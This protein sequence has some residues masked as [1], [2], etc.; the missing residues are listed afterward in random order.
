MTYAQ[1]EALS[2]VWG[3]VRDT[4]PI[5]VEDQEV[6]VTVNLHTALRNLRHD[7]RERIL[8]VDALCIN[9][10]D[11]AE[12]NSQIIM[13][14]DIYNRA[15]RVLAY[16]GDYFS[17]CEVA[18]EI[19]EKLGGDEDM[20]LY[21]HMSPGLKLTNNRTRGR[22]FEDH[23][24]PTALHRFLS[25]PWMTRVWTVQEFMMASQVV[26]LYGQ[27]EMRSEVLHAA[28]TR[29]SRHDAGCCNLQLH[30]PELTSQSSQLAIARHGL[31][32]LKLE[33]D[34]LYRQRTQLTSSMLTLEAFRHREATDQR[35]RVYG[36][37]G[38]FGAG[39]KSL[40][41]TDY[42]MKL[43]ELYKQAA[44]ADMHTTGR[45]HFLNFCYM[46]SRLKMASWIPDWSTEWTPKGPGQT[47]KWQARHA[48]HAR[49]SLNM[50]LYSADG[51]RPASAELT[52]WNSLMIRGIAIGGVAECSSTIIRGMV[53]R[54]ISQIRAMTRMDVA[55]AEGKFLCPSIP[56][57]ILI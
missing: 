11:V 29:F 3:S 49:M 32:S 15:I 53:P 48:L 56:S 23:D 10:Q 13:M 37:L 42:S 55:W 21:S 1:Y 34:M 50:S 4:K 14:A 16:L 44:L 41:R 52:L 46:G 39:W 51:G 22:G 33:W 30:P 25:S 47:S 31:A 17:G 43:E 20:H 24:A 9:Q 54:L 28:I 40:I 18:V 26:F 57:F 38:L 12:R 36:L 35:D 2:Y 45:L 8:W 7:D 5:T 19:I 6:E 27:F